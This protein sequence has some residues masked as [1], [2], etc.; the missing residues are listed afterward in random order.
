[1]IE[2]GI[3]YLHD[4]LAKATPGPWI[5]RQ[6]GY[7]PNKTWEEAYEQ[8]AAQLPKGPAYE[9]GCGDEQETCQTQHSIVGKWDGVIAWNPEFNESPTRADMELMALA[10]DLARKVIALEE[11]TNE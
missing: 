2:P 1:M 3:E 5:Y 8:F 6:Y 4:L 9:C 7:C 10:P 11:A